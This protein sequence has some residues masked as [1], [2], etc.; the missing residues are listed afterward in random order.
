MKLKLHQIYRAKP[1]FDK[2][3]NQDM[4]AKIAYRLSRTAKILGEQ[5]QEIE[6]QRMRLVKKYGEETNGQ[7]KVKDE[8]TNAFGQELLAL[9]EEDTEVDL[10]TFSLDTLPEETKLTPNEVNIIDFLISQIS[11]SS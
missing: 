11:S 4:P 5:F 9:L 8:N 3:A 1:V 7:L 6:Q 2:L 10:Q